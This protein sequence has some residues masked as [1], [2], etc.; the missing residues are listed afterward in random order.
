MLMKTEMQS[1]RVSLWAVGLMLLYLVTRLLA[2]FFFAPH[3]DEMDSAIYAENC[4]RDFFQYAF[5]TL[6]GRMFGASRAPLQ[7]WINALFTPLF[8]LPVMG[9]RLSSLFVSTAGHVAGF[10]LARRLGGIYAGGLF[11]VLIV[12][13]EHFL[14]FDVNNLGETYLVGFGTVFLYVTYLALAD[15]RRGL[16]VVSVLMMAMLLMTKYSGRL[17]WVM[18]PFV[19]LLAWR[20]RGKELNP[21]SVLRLSLVWIGIC[22]LP[23]ML[24]HFALF[25]HFREVFLISTEIREFKRYSELLAFPLS[26]WF[27]NLRYL[28]FQILAADYGWMTLLL[29]SWLIHAYRTTR[30]KTQ[31]FLLLGLA[32]F[33]F[34]PQVLVMNSLFARHFGTGMHTAYLFVAVVSADSFRRFLERHGKSFLHLFLAGIL[35][36]KSWDTYRPLVL[37]GQTDYALVE[38]KPES[39]ASGLA[40]RETLDYLQTLPE[41]HLFFDSQFGIPGSA[42]SLHR[43]MYPQLT[44]YPLSPDVLQSFPDVVRHFKTRGEPVYVLIERG[45]QERSPVYNLA[46]QVSY[47]RL[48]EMKRHYRGDT[49][50]GFVVGEIYPPGFGGKP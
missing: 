32:I 9:Y 25:Q 19:I 14:Y 49:W 50:P 39:W 37:W 38:T 7:Y 16:W 2:F 29:L 11:V 8:D 42:V 5:A 48:V 27:R 6:D 4:W 33:G 28:L 20:D 30:D 47:S 23:L 18:L 21:R 31:Y 41:G 34:L 26:D 1:N 22:A 45:N 24:V 44:L 12:F 15:R 3:N 46:F 43:V 36:F 13:S 40:M 10:L 17:W 35:A